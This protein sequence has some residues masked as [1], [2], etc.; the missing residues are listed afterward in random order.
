M[1]HL[2]VCHSILEIFLLSQKY[3]YKEIKTT[4]LEKISSKTS[5]LFGYT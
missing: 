3:S 4:R 2:F 1:F 5:K